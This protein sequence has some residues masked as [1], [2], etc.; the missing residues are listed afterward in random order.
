MC[1]EAAGDQHLRSISRSICR[2]SPL[3]A[4]NPHVSYADHE[5]RSLYARINPEH[6]SGTESFYQL[7]RT[8]LPVSRRVEDDRDYSRFWYRTVPRHLRGK[9]NSAHPARKGQHFTG[10]DVLE[11]LIEG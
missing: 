8:F 5:R 9:G 11:N 10:S 6:I 1:M 7:T 2:N 4:K 3:A